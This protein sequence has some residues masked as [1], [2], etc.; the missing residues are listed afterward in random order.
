M[1]P[2]AKSSGGRGHQ[3]SLAVPEER[4]HQPDGQGAKHPDDGEYAEKLAKDELRPPKRLGQKGEGGAI[5]DLGEKQLRG[6]RD[7]ERRAEKNQR[8]KPQSRR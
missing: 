5:L 7:G 6:R 2:A 3:L 4:D 8:T 1:R